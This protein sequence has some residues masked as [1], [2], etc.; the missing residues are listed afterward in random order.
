MVMREVDT[1]IEKWRSDDT[2]FLP[3]LDFCVVA[4]SVRGYKSIATCALADLDAAIEAL[5]KAKSVF[6]AAHGDRDLRM[7]EKYV[8]TALAKLTGKK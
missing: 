3:H 7:A 5:E 8:S 2:G 6:R 1:L 4:A